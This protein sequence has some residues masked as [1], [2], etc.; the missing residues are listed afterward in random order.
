MT[1]SAANAAAA[2]PDA[3]RIGRFAPPL[4]VPLARRARRCAARAFL[5]AAMWLVNRLAPPARAGRIARRPPPAAGLD[6]LLTGTFHAAGWAAAHLR[7]LAAS[8]SCNR[9]YVVSTFPVPAMP[10][11]VAIYPP[12][13]LRRLVGDVPARLL[14]FALL[15]LRRRPHV[16]GGFHLLVNGLAASVLARILRAR[17]LYF[18]VGG[19]LELLDGGIWAENRLFSLVETPD[20]VLQRQLLRAVASFDTVITMG[21]SAVRFFRR[22]RVRTRFHVVPGGI[23]AVHYRPADETPVTD[24]VL[25]GR[26]AEIKRIDVFLQAVA[27]A[28]HNLPGLTATVVGDGELRDSLREMA[29]RLGLQD[30]VSFVG[31][32]PGASDWLRRARVFVLTSDS[33]GLALSMMEAMAC[34]L[35]V[36]VSNVGDLPDLV[37]DGVNGFLVPRRAA[38]AFAAR[39]VDLLR[40][41]ARCRALAAQARRS[42][43]AYDIAPITR[44]WDKILTG[45]TGCRGFGRNASGG[46]PSVPAY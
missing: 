16:I 46:R 34:G 14:A 33:E 5:R 10:K 42:A 36:I 26:L 18:C 30:R 43:L 20:A 45:W 8:A 40:D 12:R 44:R 15:A 38:D 11:V 3:V 13:W 17:S 9:L 6:I 4:D 7:P 21:R 24:L 28:S 37:R 41:P 27:I 22:Q 31:Q 23:D 25:V 2:T 19:P 39:I 29:R 32:Q 1:A 35:P